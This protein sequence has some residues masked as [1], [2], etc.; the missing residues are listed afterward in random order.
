[1]YPSAGPAHRWAMTNRPGAAIA[2]MIVLAL[3]DIGGAL[4]ARRY[5]EQRSLVVLAMGCVAFAVLF[6][7]YAHGLHY[8]ELTTITFGWVVMLQVGVLIID[9]LDTGAGLP[10]DRI[11]VIGGLL[12]LQSYLVLTP[13]TT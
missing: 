1:M 8:A 4:L 11:V 6:V 3:L 5:V 13:T 2:T 7:V 12:A 10:I 9:R